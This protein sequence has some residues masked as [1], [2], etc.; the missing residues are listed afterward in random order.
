VTAN[1]TSSVAYG[2]SCVSEQRICTNGSLSGSYTNASCTPQ[3]QT[4]QTNSA[5]Y[6]NLTAS[7]QPGSN[8]S[9]SIAGFQY[10]SEV[11]PIII[12]NPGQSPANDKIIVFP[13]SNSH[14][15]T[16]NGNILNSNV[17]IPQS[18]CKIDASSAS[19]F[20]TT[21]TGGTAWLNPT[22]VSVVPWRYTYDGI[23]TALVNPLNN[24]IFF[25]RYFENQSYL[26]RYSTGVQNC[27]NP[28]ASYVYSNNIVNLGK[29]YCTCAEQAVQCTK[30][31][32]TALCKNGNN[33]C[34]ADLSDPSHDHS[35]A[36]LVSGLTM[37]W[38]STNMQS[39]YSLTA[40]ND[41]GP[42][43]WPSTG[44]F[45]GGNNLSTNFLG[46]SSAIVSGNYIYLFYTHRP[47]AG[48]NGAAGC[49][50]VARAPLSSNG[51]PGTWQNYYQGAFSSPSLPSGFSRGGISSFY[52][53]PGGPADCVSPVGLEWG[54]KQHVNWFTV[55]HIAGTPYFIAVEESATNWPDQPAY[56][57][58][59]R[60]SSDLVHWSPKQVIDN[61]PGSAWGQGKYTYGRFLNASGLNNL[62]VDANGFY[63]YGKNIPAGYQLS[64]A[65]LS[66]NVSAAQNIPVTT[67]APFCINGLNVTSYPSCV[68]PSGQTQS[69][70]TCS[71][72]TA[73]CT[74]P[75]GSVVAH[76]N[77]VTANLAS[78]VAYGQICTSQTRTCSNGTLSGSYTYATCTP[79]TATCTPL[80]AQ[81]Q[82]LTCPAGQTGTWTQG[83]TSS[84]PAGA[85]TPVWSGWTDTVKTCTTPTA[86]TYKMSDYWQLPDYGVN[87][88]KEFDNGQ[89]EVTVRTGANTITLSD[90][91]ANGTWEDTWHLTIDS[92]TGTVN[93][94]GDDFPNASYTYDAATPII[95]GS[96]LA[97][98]DIRQ[99]QW[100]NA[101]IGTANNSEWL[102]LTNHYNQYTVGSTVHSDVIAVDVKQTYTGGG[103]NVTYY[104]KRGFGFIKMDYGS[105]GIQ[106]LTRSCTSTNTTQKKCASAGATSA[107]NLKGNGSDGPVT[108]TLGNPL[109]WSWTSQ[110]VTSCL[111]TWTGATSGSVDWGISSTGTTVTPSPAGNFVMTM[112]CQTPTGSSVSDSVNLTVSPVV[113]AQALSQ[114]ASALNAII[115]ILNSLK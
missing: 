88:I 35:W 27:T 112:T 20:R 76:G 82:T 59:I 113:N 4:T 78:S 85:T 87:Q 31:N 40:M 34:P 44:Y 75:W 49:V 71:A 45:S 43:V 110:N 22:S 115:A 103:I 84:C 104:L 64:S 95:W 7:I 29:S 67:V 114:L 52:A 28:A 94:T 86:T 62:E 105:A 11:T 108:V 24:N 91:D 51:I 89:S 56:Q 2:S 61:T 12:P 39:G 70:T 77:S 60:F 53:T 41:E 26:Y 92:V 72:P 93:E 63:L 102:Q 83:R 47:P 42:V 81:T 74:A 8:L 80:A 14:V 32:D 5:S 13:G 37:G 65:R 58:A 97:I 25:S 36:T 9:I 19:I 1:L 15:C 16:T 33:I 69:G 109:T 3:T 66:V 98:G 17:S 48:Q 38:S 68:C 18:Q 10:P 106:S 6:P 21:G 46:Y 90:Y 55:A 73:S 100:G 79:A 57:Q 99:A 30:G 50:A 23:F 96:V 107:V 101:A 111:M 54:Q